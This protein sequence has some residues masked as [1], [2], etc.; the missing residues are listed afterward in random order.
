MMPEELIV[1]ELQ[2]PALEY[3]ANFKE[4]IASFLEPVRQAEIIK[5]LHKALSPWNLSFENVFWNSAARNIAE[6][7]LTLNAPLL[8]TGVQIGISGVTMTAFNTVWARANVA[9]SF[10][11][12]AADALRQSAGEEFQGQLVTRSFHLNPAQKPYKEILAQFVNAKALGAADA[13]MYGVS[14]YNKE[15]SFVIDGSAVIPGGIFIKLIRNFAPEKRMDEMGAVMRGDEE[16]VL[17]LL[18]VRVQ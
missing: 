1:A 11:Q 13:N 7:Q 6:V 10:F 17:R 3:R 8:L 16:T 14:V 2:Q 4:P 5:A 12:A 18:G 15:Y 9:V